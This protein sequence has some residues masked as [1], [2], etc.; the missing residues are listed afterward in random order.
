V[1][2]NEREKGGNNDSESSLETE[3]E[4][5]M[6]A[7]MEV[8]FSVFGAVFSVKRMGD[9]VFLWEGDHCF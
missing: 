6:E 4:A 3:M 1:E 7:E 5:G 2:S 8:A 9:S